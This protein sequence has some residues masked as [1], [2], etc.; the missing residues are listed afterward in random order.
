MKYY[1]DFAIEEVKRY[2][3]YEGKYGWKNGV[4]YDERGYYYECY[5][6]TLYYKGM[7]AFVLYTNN[8]KYPSWNMDLLTNDLYVL[9][10]EE[11]KTTYYVYKDENDSWV[12][13]ISK[14]H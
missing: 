3:Y 4:F 8:T 5:H 10:L 14:L 11:V 9:I 2:E 12:Y 13:S 6:K 7:S 1:G